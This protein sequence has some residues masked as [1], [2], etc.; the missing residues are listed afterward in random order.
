MPRTEKLERVAELKRR[1]EGSAALLLAEYRGL[2]VS[3]ITEL[4]RTLRETDASLTVVKNTLMQR[5]AAEA[6][7]ELTELLSGPSAVAFV[8]GDAVSAAKKIKAATKQFPTLVLKGGYVEGQVLSADEA[9]RLADLESREVMLSKIAGLFKG[10]MARA[11]ATFVSA[12]SRFLSLLEAYKAT[13][14]TEP[15]ADEPEADEPEADAPEAEAPEA[16]APEPEASA[17]ATSDGNG[18]E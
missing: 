8:D 10:E 16:E 5:A 7:L 2:T 9:N 6:G 17:T 12:Q 11:A 4:R 13:L 3:D 14:P 18:K 15:E 1:I